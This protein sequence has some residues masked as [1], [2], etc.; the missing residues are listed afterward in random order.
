MKQSFFK[1]RILL[2]ATALAAGAA[3]AAGTMDKSATDTTPS[4]AT[5]PEPPSRMSYAPCADLQGAALS[6]CLTKNAGTSTNNAPSSAAMAGSG[7]LDSS[8]S[9]TAPSSDATVLSAAG[10]AK[11][12][13][14]KS[15]STSDD[16]TRVAAATPRN[17]S[18]RAVKPKGGDDKFRAELRSCVQMTGAERDSCLDRAIEN[19][20]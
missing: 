5:A 6:D 10:K 15:S 12:G 17:A 1:P 13:S 2:L 20:A 7:K 3:S 8:T 4:A 18:G 14:A 11:T 16:S 19:R 9:A